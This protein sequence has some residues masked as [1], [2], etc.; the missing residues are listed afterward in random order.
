MRNH[1]AQIIRHCILHVGL[2]IVLKNDRFLLR[3]FQNDRFVLTKKTNEPLIFMFEKGVLR[4]LTKGR[5]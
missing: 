4:S 1:R 2:L 3:F 5:R